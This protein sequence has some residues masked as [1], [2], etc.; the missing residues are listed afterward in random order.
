MPF[1][2]PDAGR[3]ARR[4]AAGVEREREQVFVIRFWPA[5]AG[6]EEAWRGCVDHLPTGERR[7][8]AQLGELNE[9]VGRVLSKS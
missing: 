6:E 7:F 2:L 5:P 3:T 4:Y 9:F 1:P 8:F